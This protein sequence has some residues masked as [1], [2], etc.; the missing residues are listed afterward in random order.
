MVVLESLG[1]AAAFQPS[2]SYAY[3]VSCAKPHLNLHVTR[4][5]RSGRRIIGCSHENARY[6]GQ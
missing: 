1:G 5:C 2:G 3:E 6:A 4:H